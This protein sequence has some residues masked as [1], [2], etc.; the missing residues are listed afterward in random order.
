MVKSAANFLVG[1]RDVDT[2]LPAASFDLWEERKAIHTYSTAAVVHGLERAARIASELGKDPSPWRV[3]S[4]EI[5]AAALQHLWD[6]DSGRL[7]RGLKPR[8]TKLDASMLLALKLGL[9]EWRDP[10]TRA[11]VDAVERRL[12]V[13]GVGGVARYE[14]DTYYGFENPWLVCT[15]WLAEARLNLGERDRC[16]ELLEWVAHHGTPTRLLPEQLD[17]ATGEPRSATPLTWSHSTY[18]D[19]V[20]KFRRALGGT[21]PGDD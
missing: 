19:V 12:W 1:F 3:A 18:V 5:R 20:H 8:D 11:V 10:R 17:P 4:Q 14:G 13:K 6:E 15:L 7:L 9:L 2:G 21:D 16:W